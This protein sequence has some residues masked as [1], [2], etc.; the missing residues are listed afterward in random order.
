MCNPADA[1]CGTFRL[2]MLD[3]GHNHALIN[4]DPTN[5]DGGDRLLAGDE[6]PSLGSHLVTP[7]CGFAH[8][9]IYVGGQTVVHYAGFLSFSRQHSVAE[10]SLAGFSRGH[11]VLVRTHAAPRFQYQDVILRARS[12]LGEDRYRLLRNNCEHFCEWCVDGEHRSYQVE[13]LI[14]LRRLLARVTRRVLHAAGHFAAL[15]MCGVRGA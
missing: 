9:G 13:R 14:T 3:R 1:R 6:E 2:T 4:R 11:G 8:H 12:R 10:V 15:R 7:R 5:L